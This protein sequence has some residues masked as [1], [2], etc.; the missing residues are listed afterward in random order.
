PA[1]EADVV[2]DISQ[3][4]VDA[5]RI[6]IGPNIIDDSGCNPLWRGRGDH[7]RH[8]PAKR[9]PDE[10]RLTDPEKV[11]QLDHV[12]GVGQRI[13]AGGDRV[14]VARGTTTEIDCDYPERSE[15][16]TSELQSR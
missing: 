11:E 8:Q 10:D 6:H 12:A 1:P 4:A 7:H 2:S 13:V 14:I 16:H 15:E 5:G 9:C 3:D